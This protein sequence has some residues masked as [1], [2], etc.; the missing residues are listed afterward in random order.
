MLSLYHKATNRR[1][2]LLRGGST[3]PPFVAAAHFSFLRMG[4]RKR[5]EPGPGD[6]GRNGGLMGRKLRRIG[7]NCAIRSPRAP[8]RGFNVCEHHS[9]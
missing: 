9:M 2:T 7:Q 6:P 1:V 4:T 5:L 8:R 3:L